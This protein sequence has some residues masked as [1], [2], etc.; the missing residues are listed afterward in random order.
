MRQC[1][2]QWTMMWCLFSSALCHAE[3]T[4]GVRSVMGVQDP[5]RHAAAYDARLAAAA[6]AFDESDFENACRLYRALTG[7]RH[8]PRLSPEDRRAL[9]SA[10]SGA[11]RRCDQ[12]RRALRYLERAT[13]ELPD[14][15]DYFNLAWLAHRMER[16]AQARDVYVEYIQRWP[17]AADES[18]AQ[19]IWSLHRASSGQPDQQRRLLQAVFDSGFEDPIADMSVMWYELARLHLDRGHL[20]QARA[21]AQRVSAPEAIVRMRVDR[22]F[23]PIVGSAAERFD[24]AR[25]AE[26]HIEVLSDKVE[27]H[28]HDLEAWVNLTYALLDADR[29]DAVVEV[30]TTLLDASR[31]DRRSNAK[32]EEFIK[33]DMRLWLMNSRALALFRLGRVREAAEDLERAA[34]STEEGKPNVS[35]TLNLGM[36]RCH[37][38]EPAL[39][40]EGVRSVGEMTAYGSIVLATVHLCA[41]MQMN[42]PSG[43]AAA[44]DTIRA[45]SAEHPFSL[46]AALLRA[47]RLDEAEPLYLRLLKD[48]GDRSEALMLAQSFVVADHLPV[49]RDL[50]EKRQ[51]L[52][53]RPA[54]QAA[55]E[56]VGR[57]EAFPIRFGNGFD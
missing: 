40:V 54:V 15:A 10:A 25:Q 45:H 56:K 11:M 29:N 22:R 17:K 3:S 12:S 48:R 27:A 2:L 42:D 50:E 1:V 51:A 9:F 14:P 34:R 57:I 32:D 33:P 46:L 26:R 55:V 30:A 39:A 28:P 6:S 16:H 20:D 24:V 37:A 53:A 18:D 35:Q 41:A 5:D 23:D 52:I 31:P 47:G 49:T 7:D 38:G 13:R 21:A 36:M 4:P 44:L 19:L 8:L 43:A